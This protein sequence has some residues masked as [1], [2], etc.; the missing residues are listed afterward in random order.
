[1]EIWPWHA[2]GVKTLIIGAGMAGLTLAARLCQQG[3]DPVIIER[4]TS[5]E[6]GYAL[7]LYPV[8]SCVLHGL[9]TYEQLVEQSLAIERYELANSSGRVLQSFD[10]SVLTAALGPLLMVS[11]SDLVRLLES[12][13]AG[14]DV[15]RG[16]TVSSLNQ[17]AERVEVRFDDGT[18]EHF[19]LVVACDGI[20]SSTRELVFGPASQYHS[21]WTLWT[22]WVGPEQFE[23]TVAREWWGAGC[24]FGAYPAP[25]QVMCA[26]GG[27]T[28]ALAGSDA[29]ASLQRHLVNLIDHI[30]AVG[31]AI[32]DLRDAYSWAMRDVRSDRWVDRRVVL[33]GD[34]AVGFM[35]TAGI[36]AS[37]AMRAAAGLADELSRA[38]AASVPLALELYE[39]RCRK[40]IE[41]N[42]TDS[43]RLARVMFVRPP[44]LAWGRDQLAGLYPAKRALREIID[45][46]HQPF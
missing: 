29:R 6:G 13:C 20:D 1:M 39:K 22:W 44:L 46:A 27:P 21:G 18:V 8:G 43:R 9:G 34:A 14:A 37:N 3:R 5:I 30:P 7:G 32:G 45:S 35:P 10:M 19:D 25:G 15:R 36:G 12:S 41:R 42:Q 23:S 24:I 26:A 2:D 28:S 4:S 38:D 33:C 17:E 16:V 11:R 31:A 40:I